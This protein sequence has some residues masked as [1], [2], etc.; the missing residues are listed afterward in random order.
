[1]PDTPH[2]DPPPPTSRRYKSGEVLAEKYRLLDEV[3]RGGM[4]TVWLARNR[5]LEVDVAV[6]LIDLGRS[7]DQ[8]VLVR[9][10]LQEART[11][12]RLAHSAVARVFDY[13]KTSLGDPFI[14][15]EFLRGESL[16]ERLDR[17]GRMDPVE[18]VRVL[19]PIVD[20]LA[21]A[22]AEDIVHR[23]VKSGNIFL[24]S[25]ER[26]R[27]QPKLLDF[28]I[29]NFVT[30][31]VRITY[32]GS[33]LGTPGYMPPEQARGM[34]VD[35]RAD[36]WAICIVLYEMLTGKLPFTG[37]NY[38]AVLYSIINHAPRPLAAH[39]VTDAD[40]QRLIDRGLR[41]DPEH[42]WTAM[43]EL[44]E[45]L[46][47][48]LFERGVRV[49]ICGASLRTTWLE[50]GLSDVQVEL[51]DSEHP[52]PTPGSSPRVRPSPPPASESTSPSVSAAARNPPAIDPGDDERS[53]RSLIS[54]ATAGDDHRD[55]VTASFHEELGLWSHPRSRWLIVAAGG[56]LGAIVAVVLVA[57][58]PQ[59]AISGSDASVATASAA[60]PEPT[61]PEADR[62]EVAAAEPSAPP[63][64]SVGNPDEARD[65]EPQPPP[66]PAK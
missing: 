6:K 14:V 43:R 2:S 54:T 36:V 61:G 7:S 9:R 16:D 35:F 30:D 22:H 15:S 31:K 37:K 49:D 58:G 21:A 20:A 65:S 18:A 62:P 56:V 12:A 55:R 46:A 38:N 60:T 33:L 3:G 41:K 64:A 32:E 28:G 5:L 50:S 59:T 51:R 26:G 40:L 42:R 8:E 52:P 47:L 34:E 25:D 53:L 57:R 13:G 1:M 39:G 10:V 29:A 24:S 4:G 66:A 45:A 44:G 48:W 27:V 11:S 23:D 63:S 19:L 17:S